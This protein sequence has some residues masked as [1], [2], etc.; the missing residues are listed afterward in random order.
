MTSIRCSWNF[1]PTFSALAEK[2]GVEHHIATTG[3]P[4][5]ARAHR[6]GPIKLAV[7]KTEFENMERLGIVRRSNSPWASP[8]HIVPKPGGGWR[9]CGDYRRL[10]EA[11]TPDRY[12][13][14]H[15]QDF[16]AH[17]AGKVIFSKVDLVQGY[18]QVPVQ[19]SDIPKTAVITQFGLFEF[20]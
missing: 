1:Q 15:V 10:N 19:Q 16:S 20:L 12:P 14:P 13:I 17:L 18:H 8:L 9:P 7:A 11:T 2:H 5:Y 3:P 4:V 6:L